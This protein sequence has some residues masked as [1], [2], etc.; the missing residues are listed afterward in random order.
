[1]EIVK[2]ALAWTAFAVFH[3]ATVS[4]RYE[5]LARRVMGDRPYDA[6]HRLLFTLYSAA[7]A[8]ATLLYVHSLPDVPL[9]RAEGWARVALH[10][11][12][13]A[14]IALLL[15]TPWDFPEFVG[16]RPL[17][18]MLRGETPGSGER[19]RLHTGKA[20]GLVRHP[21]YLG[22]SVILAFHP[23][24]TRNSLATAAMILAYFYAATFPEERR[25][26]RKFGDAYRE[27][28]KRVPRFLPLPRP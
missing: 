1:V 7:A 5:R 19:D 4:E 17:I 10:A 22:F 25:L 6:F 26:E 27:Y 21:L 11:V 15:W 23:V 18:R 3:S 28:K 2:I 24:Q 9:Y 8:A 16:L 12:Q 14:G 13:G 20:Y